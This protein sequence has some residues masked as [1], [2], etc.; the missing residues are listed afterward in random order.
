VHEAATP[1]Q[2]AKAYQEALAALETA[3][4]QLEPLPSADRSR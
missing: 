4:G 2:S 3:I 1:E